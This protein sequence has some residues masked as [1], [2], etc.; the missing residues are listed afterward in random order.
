MSVIED[1]EVVPHVAVRVV[2]FG[3]PFCMTKY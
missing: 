2:V 3:M 1:R